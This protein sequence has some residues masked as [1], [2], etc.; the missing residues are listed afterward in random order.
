[1]LDLQISPGP[2]G[3][4]GKNNFLYLGC[5]FLKVVFRIGLLDSFHKFSSSI[6]FL[7]P[8]N[9]KISFRSQLVQYFI[10]LRYRLEERESRML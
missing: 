10:M 7:I 5:V 1:M 9:D 3:S 4:P 2:I 8:G 6:H